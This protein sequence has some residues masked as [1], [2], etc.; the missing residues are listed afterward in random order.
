MTMP[1]ER[2]R[3]VLQTRE[4]LQWVLSADATSETSMQA[5]HE[6]RALLR[7]FPSTSDMEIAHHACPMW[8]GAA[9]E[10]SG[11][12]SPDD[13][14]RP[15]GEGDFTGHEFGEGPTR[16]VGP[17]PAIQKTVVTDGTL[18]APKAAHPGPQSEPSK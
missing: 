15:I 7:H 18:N 10:R 4:F 11:P 5:K 14:D 13:V 17:S 2:T 8:F 9:R 16:A 12:T 1:Y 6:A 3:A